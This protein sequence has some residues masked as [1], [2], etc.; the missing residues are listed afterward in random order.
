MPN[1]VLALGLLGAFATGDATPRPTDAVDLGSAPAQSYVILAAHDGG[2]GGPPPGKGPGG[3][4]DH[5]EDG[6]D[7][8]DEGHDDTSHDDG[9]DSGED[10]GKRGPRYMGGRGVADLKTGF[11]HRFD[12][13][14]VIF[15]H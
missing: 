4:A 14:A 2:R 3:G 10:E 7:S 6:D 9:H 1:L 12:S 8:H 15:R 5:H 11:G 13:E